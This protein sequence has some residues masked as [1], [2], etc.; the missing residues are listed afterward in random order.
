MS[1]SIIVNRYT[2]SGHDPRFGTFGYIDVLGFRIHT[3]EQKWEY[4][5]VKWPAGKPNESCIPAGTYDIVSR[6]SP[7][8]KRDMYYLVNESLGI[9]LYDGPKPTDRGSCMFH[10][11]GR[12]SEVEGC[13]GLGVSR[14]DKGGTPGLNKVDL[15]EKFLLDYIK[16]FGI[17]KCTIRY[18]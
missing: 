1:G 2:Q 12:A 14:V 8:K 7:K 9:Y 4:D 5:P 18:V 10:K 11:A 15:A 6:Y 17:K 16:T 3:V 13:V